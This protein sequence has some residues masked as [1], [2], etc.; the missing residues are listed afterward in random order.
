[1][2]PISIPYL[3][4]ED[5][6]LAIKAIQDGFIAN[7][8]Q[9]NEFEEKFASYCNRKYGVTCSNGTVA[10]YL[11]IKALNL[12]E[13]SEVILPSMTIMSCLT[14]IVENNLTPVF[15]DINSITWNVDINSVRSKITSNT[16][17]LIVVDTYGLT[18]NVDEISKLKQ[19]YPNIKI[20]E[21]ASEA[22][23]S[24]YKGIKAGSVGDIS[25]FSFY[26][27]KIITTGEGGMVLTDDEE[28][29]QRLLLLKNLNFTHRKKYIHS[30][31]GW[32]FR[33]TNL[34]CCLGLGQLQ[35][36]DK[37]IEQRRRIAERYNNNLKHVHIQLPFEDENN[38]NVYWYY[39]IL[40][41]SNYDNVLKSLDDNGIDYRHFFYPLHLQPFMKTNISLPASQ[42][43]AEQGLILP[44]F[45]ELTNDQID[46]ISETILKQL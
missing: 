22:H 20:I 39:S 40:I 43:V 41:K 38:Y 29:Y 30:D 12:P 14:A 37:T 10:L 17:A 32:N 34:Q 45:T 16:S 2:I 35:N 33:L 15:C 27:N 8:K 21:D 9:I 3:Y 25:T 36:I 13:G 31:A 11:A 19:D 5:K 28:T 46:F 23:G 1:M 18:V 6:Q 42:Y 7:G 26:A 24:N 4:E 44:T